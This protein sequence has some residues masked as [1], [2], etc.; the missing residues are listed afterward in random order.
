M[1]RR[2]PTICYTFLLFW[3][4][5]QPG[6]AANWRVETVFGTVT[7]EDLAFNNYIGLLLNFMYILVGSVT[8]IRL[9]MGGLRYTQAGGDVDQAKSAKNTIIHA[10]TGL[11]LVF[12]AFLITTYFIDLD[13]F[14]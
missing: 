4:L 8:V 10:L 6:F 13:S 11:A 7:D 14:S 2:L 1:F 5:P 12:S 9:L 3:L